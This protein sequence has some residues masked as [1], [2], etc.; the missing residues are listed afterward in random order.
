LLIFEPDAEFG[1]EIVS[2]FK[3]RYQLKWVR[4]LKN[5]RRSLEHDAPQLILFNMDACDLDSIIQ[6]IQNVSYP[7][8]S[9]P[10]LCAF[11]ASGQ[12]EGVNPKSNWPVL[13]F[14]KDELINDF[15]LLLQHMAGKETRDEN[16]DK[17]DT[18]ISFV[19]ENETVKNLLDKINFLADID[20]HI[21]LTGTTGTGKTLLAKYIHQ[22]S[23]RRFAPF[24]HINCAAIPDTLL[25]AELF[26]YRK[27]AFTGAVKDTPGKFKAAV[28]GTIFLDEI[29]EIPWHLQAKLLKVLDEKEYY[30]VGSV[31]PE[32]VRARVIAATNIDLVQAV[33]GKKFRQD[34]YYRLNTFQLHIPPLNQRPEDIELLFNTFVEDYVKTHH[35]HKPRI[36]PVIFGALK[37][38]DWP[39]N[40]RE[41]ENL[42][43]ALLLYKPNGIT[44]DLLPSKIFQNPLSRTIQVGNE[45]QTLRQI[46]LFY[47]HY[48]LD[49]NKGNKRKTARQLGIDR[50]TLQRILDKS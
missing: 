34:L 23:K 13:I 40:V 26:G 11:N 30:P 48:L 43:E 39:G 3:E 42:V 47:V 5:L 12:Y 33:A 2:Y 22:H 9:S 15:T 17:I 36:D 6:S 29:G 14:S 20:I 35:I 32:K 28:N 31:H 37:E 8:F 4:N 10:L 7:P 1:K 18:K 24:L 19:T 27:G 41:L 49:L 21:L 25:E 16:V 50:K 46:K 44:A 45:V 38:Y